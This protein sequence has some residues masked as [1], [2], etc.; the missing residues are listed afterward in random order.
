LIG[1]CEIGFGNV[2]EVTDFVSIGT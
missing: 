1:E 2:S